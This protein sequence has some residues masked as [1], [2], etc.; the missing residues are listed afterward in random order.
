M[1]KF[2]TLAALPLLLLSL[3]SCEAHWF[4][5]SYDVP[6][7]VIAVPSIIFVFVVCFIL[8]FTLTKRQYHCPQCA[9]SFHPKWYAAAISVHM[10]DKRVFRCPHCGY[11]GFC[12]PTDE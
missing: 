10:G 3:T 5:K 12:N 7:Y 11:K 8:G 1:K 6:W 4:G 2:L 9:K